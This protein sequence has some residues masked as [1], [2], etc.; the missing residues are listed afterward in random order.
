[1]AIDGVL[2]K[3]FYPIQ[4]E[5]LAKKIQA[6]WKELEDFQTRRG[7]VYNG[8]SD[9]FLTKQQVELEPHVWHKIYTQ[10]YTQVFGYAA[11]RVTSKQ[12]GCGGAE[13][14]WGAFKHLRNGKWLHMSAE[15]SQRQM[16]VC[17]A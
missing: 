5:D 4:Q 6:F 8:L 13:Q 16:T 14:T 10:L 12:L 11:C 15:K 9:P 7:Q 2:A 3:I 1:M 17:G